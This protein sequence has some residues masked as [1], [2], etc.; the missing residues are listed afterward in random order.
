MYEFV[1][2]D[3]AQEEED[4]TFNIECCFDNEFN[5]QLIGVSK[6]EYYDQELV[7]VD[8]IE[9]DPSFWSYLNWSE[10]IEDLENSDFYAPLN[11]N[12]VPS[13]FMK[14]CRTLFWNIKEKEADHDVVPSTLHW[15][16]FIY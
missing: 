14:F 5:N 10:Y 3:D 2:I 12:T 4:S 9:I 6:L 11:L 16:N 15:G 8:Y 1:G 13:I 7:I